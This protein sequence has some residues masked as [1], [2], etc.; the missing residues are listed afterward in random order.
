VDDETL[1]QIARP[2][3]EY[4]NLHQPHSWFETLNWSQVFPSAN[5]ESNHSIHIDLGAGDG[6]FIL[7]RAKRLPNVSFLAVE[8]LL[9]RA[10]KIA[11]KSAREGL[12]N[13]RVLRIEATYAVERLFPPSSVDSIT[14]LFPDPWPKRRHHKNR[15]IQLPFLVLCSKVLKPKGWLAIKTDNQNYFQYISETLSIC[16][17]FK[18]WLEA[19]PEQLLPELTDFEKDFLKEGRPIH[20]IAAKPISPSI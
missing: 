9:G 4:P 14:I 16:P 2:K 13:I 17:H 3:K 10:R 12:P 1:Q 8:R 7:Q 11:K 15:L 19:N 6:G 5:T 18:P 20:F